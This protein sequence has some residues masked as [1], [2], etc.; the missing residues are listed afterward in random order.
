MC[1]QMCSAPNRPPPA[2]PNGGPVSGRGHVVGRGLGGGGGGLVYGDAG[3]VVAAQASV[4]KLRVVCGDLDSKKDDGR[5]GTRTWLERHGLPSLANDLP[6]GAVLLKPP[7]SSSGLSGTLMAENL[8]RPWL[9]PPGQSHCF[10]LSHW[11]RKNCFDDKKG[12]QFVDATIR[13]IVAKVAVAGSIGQSPYSVSFLPAASALF[14]LDRLDKSVQLKSKS[15]MPFAPPHLP[16][17][18]HPIG[19]FVF[20]FCVCVCVCVCACCVRC[21]GRRR[22]RRICAHWGVQGASGARA[23][24]PARIQSS[25]SRRGATAAAPAPI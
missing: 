13:L 9:E 21:A 6:D 22:Q 15:A 20:M 16:T 2:P 11:V 23:A 8:S 7:N 14:A 10:M 12:D 25:A 17:H 1:A 5:V 3:L 18:Q 19:F 24:A 4:A